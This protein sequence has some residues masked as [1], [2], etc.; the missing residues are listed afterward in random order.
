MPL[1]NLLSPERRRELLAPPPAGAVLDVVFDTDPT[2]EVDDQFA[3]VWALLHPERLRVVGLHACPYGF[4][5]DLLKA[6]ALLSVLDSNGIDRR[7]TELGMTVEDVPTLTPAEGVDAAEGELHAIAALL[8]PNVP[9]RGGARTYLP[10]AHTPVVSPA[11][12]HL[13]ELAHTDREGPLYV[14]GIGCATNL[15]SALLLDPSI[16]D[17]VVLTWTSAYPSFW[18]GRNASF[19]LAQDLHAARVLLD[20]GCALH[21]LP[22]YYVGEKLRTSLPELQSALTGGGRIASYLLDTFTGHPL[23]GTDRGTSKV[24]WDLVN[25]AWLLNPAW[26][27][28]GLLPTPVLDDDLRW[29]HDPARHEMLESVDIDRDAVFT[30]LFLRVAEAD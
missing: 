29:V 10:D 3:M 26:L 16:A 15:A 18:P 12:E 7:L 21:Y 27:V 30:D 2:N 11:A 28:S 17:K 22:G 5:S 14:V 4:S 19:N 23:I 9:V 13:I 1:P 6:G 24:L 8:A 20:S 25:V